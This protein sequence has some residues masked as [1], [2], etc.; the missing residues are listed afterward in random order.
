MDNTLNPQ[1]ARR[2]PGRPPFSVKDLPVEV[3]FV[4]CSDPMAAKAEQDALTKILAGICRRILWQMQEEV[5]K[6]GS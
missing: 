3:T 5:K 6:G 1:P 2:K 4:P